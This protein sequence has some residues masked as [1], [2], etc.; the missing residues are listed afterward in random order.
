M[1][2]SILFFAVIIIFAVSAQAQ[3]SNPATWSFTAKKLSGGKYELH[4]T[5]TLA[6]GWHVYSQKSS[7]NGPGPTTITFNSNALVN[8][9]GTVKEVGQL[10]KKYEEVFNT[11]VLFYEKKVDFIKTVTVKGN[12][13]TNVSGNIQYTLCNDSKCLP[14]KTV[15]FSISLN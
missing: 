7:A 1:K 8:T 15:D 4:L 6:N 14:P 11:N 5:A 10:V 2:K 13:K 12:I 3:I 9:K